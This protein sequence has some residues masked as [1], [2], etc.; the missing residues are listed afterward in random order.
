M[1]LCDVCNADVTLDQATVYTADEFRRVVSQGFQPH[2][3]TIKVAVAFGSTR[4]QAVAQ[5]KQG[6]V[7]QSTTDWALCS[8]CAAK[9]ATWMPKPK[10]TGIRTKSAEQ[11]TPEMLKPVQPSSARAKAERAAASERIIE[12]EAESLKEAREQVKSQIPEG[13]HVLSE[14]VISDG[15]PK[16]VKAIAESTEAAFAKAQSEIPNNADVIGKKE[17]AAPEQ[18]V[19]I[20]EAFE[21]QSARAQVQSQIRDSAIIKALKLTASGKKGFLGLG[22]APNQ[23]EA[24]VF[25]QA[26]AVITYKTKAKIS[27]KIGEKKYKFRN[28][29]YYSNKPL[30]ELKG[31]ILLAPEGEAEQ[32][33]KSKVFIGTIEDTVGTWIDEIKRPIT[34]IGH[35]KTSE[36]VRRAH[37]G[38]QTVLED[39]IMTGVNACLKNTKNIFPPAPVQDNY[40]IT[41]AMSEN[42][43]TGSCFLVVLVY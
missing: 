10:G 27:A 39:I 15:K 43:V 25:Q 28:P 4:E 26:V 30:S 42:E 40:Y 14:K 32:I 21:E 11:L 23:Y 8:A 17:L 13:L 5:W 37:A 2:E 36:L 19:I 35:H 6:L 18:R 33:A 22:K 20:V 3:A 16:T 24:D 1:G 31:I 7:A 29:R 9:A 12:I 38:D 41:R 34:A